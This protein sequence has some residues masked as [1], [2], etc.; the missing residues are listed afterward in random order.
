MP[1]KKKKIILT[2]RSFLGW[3]LKK[4]KSKLNTSKTI[5][6]ILS[7]K[8]QNYLDNLVQQKYIMER[9]LITFLCKHEFLHNKKHLTI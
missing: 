3:A 2:S 9:I 8:F 6:T 1:L 7:E 5:W 4:Y